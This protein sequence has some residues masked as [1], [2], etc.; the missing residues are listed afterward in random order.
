MSHPCSFQQVN[1]AGELQILGDAASKTLDYMR[2]V[3][4]FYNTFKPNIC[5]E[6]IR[7]IDWL[8]NGLQMY[9]QIFSNSILDASFDLV[10]L[11]VTYKVKHQHGSCT[12]T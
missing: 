2:F 3:I 12:F 1:D 8:I 4:T 7:H 11:S 6:K 5:N 9:F 10:I